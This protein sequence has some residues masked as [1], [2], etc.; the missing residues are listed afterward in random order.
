MLLPALIIPL[1]A[2]VLTAL[3]WR[4]GLRSIALA[5]QSGGDVRARVLPAMILLVIPVVMLLGL[6][7]LRIAR[8][9]PSALAI[10]IFMIAGVSSIAALAASTWAVPGFRALAFFAAAAWSICFGLLLWAI[11]ALSGLR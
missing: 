10:E 4:S 3:A 5:K 7:G 2:L 8:M 6:C 11:S 9:Q 1:L